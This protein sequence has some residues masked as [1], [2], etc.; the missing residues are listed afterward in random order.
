MMCSVHYVCYSKD[1]KGHV[2]IGTPAKLGLSNCPE[3]VCL[4]FSDL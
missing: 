4:D 3:E 1:V 2:I